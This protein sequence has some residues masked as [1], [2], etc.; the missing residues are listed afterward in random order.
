MRALLSAQIL[1][2]LG[3]AALPALFIL[4]AEDVLD[5][6]PAVAGALL[7]GFGIFTGITMLAAGRARDPASHKSLLLVGVAL[8]GGGFL[9]VAG[10]TSALFAAPGLLAAAV[11]FG[12]VSTIGLPVPSTQR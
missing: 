3:Y 8:M 7:A 11:G 6:R 5:L 1:W 2:V 4:H 12:L 10:T 9:A